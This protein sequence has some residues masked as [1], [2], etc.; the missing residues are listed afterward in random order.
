MKQTQAQQVKNILQELKD[1]KIAASKVETD[2]KLPTGVLWKVKTS[3]VPKGCPGPLELSEDRMEKLISYRDKKIDK[4]KPKT[5]IVK[6]SATLSSV[7]LDKH[8]QE[9]KKIKE[10]V[11]KKMPRGLS[12]ADQ[13]KW[14]TE[15]A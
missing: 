1:I 8:P 9:Y 7:R 4:A 14:R 12:L 3:F 11:S 6:K 5:P 15:N 13:L 10:E 2:L